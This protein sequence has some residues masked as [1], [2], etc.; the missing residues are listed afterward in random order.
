MRLLL[1][2]SVFDTRLNF[3][4]EADEFSINS[5]SSNPLYPLQAFLKKRWG[6]EKLTYP[7]LN[8][9][10]MRSRPS[11]IKTSKILH[12]L[13]IKCPDYID[14]VKPWSNGLL[15]NKSQKF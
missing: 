5:D 11:C 2:N 15:I 1:S 8:S 4:K 7:E 10:G 9:S 3:S 13:N 14:L 12:N 6:S